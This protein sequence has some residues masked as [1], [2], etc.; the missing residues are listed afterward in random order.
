MEEEGV[1]DSL[2]RT[3]VQHGASPMAGATESGSMGLCAE[4]WSSSHSGERGAS[5][6]CLS[7][8]KLQH[9]TSLKPSK[10]ARGGEKNQTQPQNEV[11]M[12]ESHVTKG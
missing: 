3:V 4:L 11:L 10:I 7:V 6:S 5:L 1:W 9:K 2:S 12:P 8:L